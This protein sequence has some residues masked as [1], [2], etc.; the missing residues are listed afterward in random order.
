MPTFPTPEPL[1]VTVDIVFGNIRFVAGER[2]DTVVRVRPVDPSRELDVQ[3]A[4]HVVLEFGDGRLVV[5]HPKRRTVFTTKYGS[6][7][8]VVELPSGSDV[9]GDT[10]EGEYVVKGVVGSCRLQNAIGDIRVGQ[11]DR[12]RL[13]TTA[14]KVIVDQV[15][16]QAD[17]SANGDV[18]IRRVGGSA[19]VK[20][21]GGHCWIGEAEGDVK[22]GS[23]IGDI[24]VDVARAAVDARTTNG[25]IRVGQVGRGSVDL[26]SVIGTVDV[27]VPHGTGVRLDAHTS[28]GRVHN[29][30]AGQPA[31]EQAE[32]TVKVRARSSAGGIVVRR[33]EQPTATRAGH[34]TVT[35]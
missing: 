33:A 7:D 19:V 17:V 11:A 13:K 27:G 32:R 18:R 6:V 26:H 29:H 2:A 21:A 12:V 23:A 34:P 10:A 14:G 8:V 25:N 31:P 22:V 20:N 3:A 24:T 16:G 1:S 15:R 5:R 28:M 30:L 9:R 35:P 4:E